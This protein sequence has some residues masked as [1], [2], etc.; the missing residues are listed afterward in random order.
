MDLTTIIIIISIL[1]SILLAGLSLYYSINNISQ[2]SITLKNIENVKK[3]TEIIDQLSILERSS[4]V[5]R[6]ELIPNLQNSLMI[7]VSNLRR[8]FKDKVITKEIIINDENE[9]KLKSDENGNICL[10]NP[11]MFV[12]IDKKGN[13]QL[14]VNL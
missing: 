11:K 14:P 12:C 6:K 1:V 9:W 3:I 4:D 5:T 10:L 7:E 2:Q 13:L 8:D